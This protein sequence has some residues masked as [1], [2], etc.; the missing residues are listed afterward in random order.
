MK[1]RIAAACL[2]ALVATVPLAHDPDGGELS[3]AEKAYHPT[4]LYVD[5][6]Y[7]RETR[8]CFGEDTRGMAGNPT[9]PSW[10]PVSRGYIREVG[11]GK[12]AHWHQRV[13]DGTVFAA[14]HP[15]LRGTNI[16]VLYGRESDPGYVNHNM[17]VW[18]CGNGDTLYLLFDGILNPSTL[19][20][21]RGRSDSRGAGG[22][23]AI[24]VGDLRHLDSLVS[25]WRRVLA[26]I[27]LSVSDGFERYDC[28]AEFDRASGT[29][30]IHRR[31][32]GSLVRL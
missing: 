26:A 13:D 12:F 10:P 18:C 23:L 25:E 24:K 29:W 9:P 31:T 22:T 2:T 19:V 7:D 20:S 4:C 5:L 28:V 3:L 17:H 14:G 30:V 27:S 21:L 1:H 16:V 8:L 32:D 6:R 11:A 15:H